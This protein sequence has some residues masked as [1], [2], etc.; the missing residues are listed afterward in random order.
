M[1]I[2]GVKDKNNKLSEGRIKTK[3]ELSKIEKWIQNWEKRNPYNPK[4]LLEHN[5]K[6]N[7]DLNRFLEKEN[8]S[9]GMV[10][11]FYTYGV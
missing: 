7:K 5:R 10:K 8:F 3:K 2:G 11:L 6:F 4:K 9:P 1:F